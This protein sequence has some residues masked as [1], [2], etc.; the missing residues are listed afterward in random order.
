MH[1]NNSLPS[2]KHSPPLKYTLRIEGIW[3]ASVM[4]C[5]RRSRGIRSVN[6]GLHAKQQWSQEAVHC[7]VVI[8]VSPRG[9][10]S[11]ELGYFGNGGYGAEFAFAP[12][13]KRILNFVGSTLSSKT[14]LPLMMI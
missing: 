14:V 9:R 8:N 3:A 5:D 11:I 10:A 13:P 6:R 2:K 12:I 4:S 1:S 7:L